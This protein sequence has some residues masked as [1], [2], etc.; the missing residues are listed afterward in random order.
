MPDGVD[1]EL[2]VPGN[3][4]SA[5]SGIMSKSGAPNFLYSVFDRIS[6][7]TYKNRAVKLVALPIHPFVKILL[8]I[9]I[10]DSAT[11]LVVEEEYVNRGYEGVI[12]RDPNGAYKFGRS[13][14]LEQGMMKIKRKKEI[15]A[16]VV[17]Y[18]EEMENLNPK[19]DNELGLSKRSSHQDNL[20]P[21][22]SLGALIVTHPDFEGTFKVGTGF[23]ASQRKDYWIY[24]PTL[25]QQQVLISYFPHGVKDAPRHPVFKGFISAK[26][27]TT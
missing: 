26:T 2:T 24:P 16:T 7:E 9:E 27:L 20:I 19:E 22:Q 13:T 11:L 5:L 23:T 8:P 14:P 12:I 21:K 18:E 4:H 1:G 15:I 17:G 10:K 3:F 25:L 6:N